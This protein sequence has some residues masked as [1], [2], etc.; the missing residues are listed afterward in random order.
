MIVSCKH[1]KDCVHSP[2]LTFEAG[3]QT[4]K[5]EDD[6]EVEETAAHSHAIHEVLPQ[7]G[8]GG[9]DGYLCAHQQVP[10]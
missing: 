8:V 5:T 7:D 4:T 6:G 3:S 1:F 2:H 9:G 10:T